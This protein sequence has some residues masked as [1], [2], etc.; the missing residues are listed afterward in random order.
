VVATKRAR[1]AE[2]ELVD[3]LVLNEAYSHPTS[4][5]R[6]MGEWARS[7]QSGLV[8]RPS[9]LVGRKVASSI[10]NCARHEY[11]F[12]NSEASWARTSPNSDGR[13]RFG[14]LDVVLCERR[15]ENEINGSVEKN[16]VWE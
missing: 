5:T 8:K 7:S 15:G 9:G 13:G 16:F 6:Q 11:D 4:W 14:W 10:A 2:S 3:K 12:P 1:A